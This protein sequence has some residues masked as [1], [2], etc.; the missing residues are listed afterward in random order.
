M[1]GDDAQVIQAPGGQIV[2]DHHRL[3]LCQKPFDQVRADEAR[4]AGDEDLLFV[5][6]GAWCVSGGAC[7][8]VRGA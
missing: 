7:G 6:R 8:V 5:V 3:A 2:Y 1:A 4:A